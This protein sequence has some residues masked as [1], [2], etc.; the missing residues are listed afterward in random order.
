MGYKGTMVFYKVRLKSSEVNAFCDFWWKEQCHLWTRNAMRTVLRDKDDTWE[1]STHYYRK[2]A[3]VENNQ[4]GW[5]NIFE[6]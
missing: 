4:K 1:K 5:Q 3:T 6:F 2:S